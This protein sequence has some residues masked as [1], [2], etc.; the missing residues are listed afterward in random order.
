MPPRA[1]PSQRHRRRWVRAL[2][3]FFAPRPRGKE[4]QRA[5]PSHQH[6]ESAGRSLLRSL[7]EFIN[8]DPTVPLWRDSPVIAAFLSLLP[9]MGH[10]YMGRRR[11]ATWLLPLG[12]A[13]GYLSARYYWTMSG[14]WALGFYCMA[15][16]SC[17]F[18]VGFGRRSEFSFRNVAISIILVFVLWA[19]FSQVAGHFNGYFGTHHVVIDRDHGPFE[20]GDTLDFDREAYA[21]GEP[22]LGDV[23]LTERGVVDVVLARPRDHAVWSEG[24][25]YLNG[26]AVPNLRP[27]AF[28]GSPPPFDVNVPADRYL[29]LPRTRGHEV[30]SSE[31]FAR[32]ALPLA[33]VSRKEILYRYGGPLPDEYRWLDPERPIPPPPAEE[34]SE[35]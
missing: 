34:E 17:M 18:D 3:L 27:I 6:E 13:L 32:Y 35:E 19:G 2:R 20:S 10:F 1:E 25:L 28:D 12:L 33:L 11:P 26:E 4:R 5:R 22:Q 29:V 31:D 9:G 23:V 30:T 8:S 15:S 7:R 24:M 14:A 21:D 16:A